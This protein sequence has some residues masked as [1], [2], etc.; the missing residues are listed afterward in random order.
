MAKQKAPTDADPFAELTTAE[1]QH[2]RAEFCLTQLDLA[3]LLG[4]TGV[5]CSHWEQ[6]LK[7]PSRGKLAVL[8]Q[9]RA[10]SRAYEPEAKLALYARIHAILRSAANFEALIA[11]RMTEAVLG[12]ELDHEA[13]DALDNLANLKLRQRK[14]S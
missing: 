12:F 9:M 2:V 8:R 6:G 3:K 7:T 14:E 4:V 5:T 1:I 10:I 11:A 13:K